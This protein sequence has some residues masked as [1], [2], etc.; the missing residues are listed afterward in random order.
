ME[1]LPRTMGCASRACRVA[2]ARV[3]LGFFAEAV[4]MLGDLGVEVWK[5]ASGEID[6]EDLAKAIAGFGK[7]RSHIFWNE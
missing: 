3:C 4:A 1:F 6:N 5:I 7:T 2:W